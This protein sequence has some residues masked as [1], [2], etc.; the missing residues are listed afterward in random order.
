M[1]KSEKLIVGYTVLLTIWAFFTGFHL[2]YNDL[3]GGLFGGRI[4][5]L[6]YLGYLFVLSLLLHS[7]RKL[8]DHRNDNNVLILGF[9]FCSIF[10]LTWIS[11][12]VLETF[13][14][15]AILHVAGLLLLRDDLKIRVFDLFVRILSVILFISLIE[16]LIFFIT[17]KGLVIGYVERPG[18]YGEQNFYQLLFNLII[19]TPLSFYRFQ[20]LSEEPGVVGTICGLLI[21]L[22]KGKKEYKREYYIFIIAGVLSFSLAFYVMFIIHLITGKVNTR[23]VI[24]VALSGVLLY[25]LLND[26]FEHYI[27][28]RIIGRSLEEIDDRGTADFKYQF[29]T[30]LENGKLWLGIYHGNGIDGAGMKIFI[31]RY[32]LLSLFFLFTSYTIVYFKEISKYRSHIGWALMFFFVFWLSFYQKHNIASMEYLVCYFLAPLLYKKQVKI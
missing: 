26:F 7:Q 19:D 31:W 5:L 11:T 3:I 9:A 16:F 4:G 21:F 22:L 27:L 6:L 32:G 23:M 28:N 13:F 30:A 14:I 1:S 20:S 18:D 2:A 15:F 29:Q 10:L 24:I 17:G 25:F 12:G 8:F